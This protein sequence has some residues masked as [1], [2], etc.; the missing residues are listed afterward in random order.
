MTEPEAMNL[1]R[2]KVVRTLKNKLIL[3]LFWPSFRL[4]FQSSSPQLQC[5]HLRRLHATH[6]HHTQQTQKLYLSH[7]YPII[8]QTRT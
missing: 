5:S 3:I 4:R 6:H 7:Y 8:E 1:S 2:Q